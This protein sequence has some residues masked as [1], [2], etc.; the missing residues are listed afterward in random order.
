M[1]MQWV[2]GKDPSSHLLCRE[3]SE[4]T[5][6]EQPEQPSPRPAQEG[7]Q[8][9]LSLG[10]PS[11][12]AGSLC[13]QPHLAVAALH[14]LLSVSSGPSEANNVPRPGL[15]PTSLQAAS[16]RRPCSQA[17]T[18]RGPHRL[19]GPQATKAPPIPGVLATPEFSGEGGHRAPCT[20]ISKSKTRY[21]GN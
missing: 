21:K 14:C 11:A 7:L 10:S 17:S 12:K 9:R 6:I 16:L 5:G 18:P 4:T 3:T 13:G 8:G 20:A 1:G 2:P 15:F 19:R